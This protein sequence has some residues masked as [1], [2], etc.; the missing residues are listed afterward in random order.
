MRAELAELRIMVQSQ[1]NAD[2]DS[3]ELI[4]RLI[5]AHDARVGAL[6]QEIFVF[7]HNAIA[8]EVSLGPG[9]APDSL[10]AQD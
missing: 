9:S 1:L 6:E 8:P 4:G 7:A 3:T 10:T 2:A 5:Q